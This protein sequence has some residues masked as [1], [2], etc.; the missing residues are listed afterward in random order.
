VG[1]NTL[2]IRADVKFNVHVSFCCFAASFTC[3]WSVVLRSLPLVMK[4]VNYFLG[5]DLP[6]SWTWQGTA[7]DQKPAAMV[8][9]RLNKHDYMAQSFVH[10][11]K[12]HP[13]IS[14]S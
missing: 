13:A 1:K 4:T 2:F 6:S 11:G 5:A 12:L 8:S 10:D 7:S 9:G 14:L 3:T